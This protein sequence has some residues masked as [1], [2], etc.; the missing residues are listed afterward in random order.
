MPD[1]Y[2]VHMVSPDDDRSTACG[3]PWPEGPGPL[4]PDLV[5]PPEGFRVD[6]P[7][8]YRPEQIRQCAAC[9]RIVLQ[10]G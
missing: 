6:P 8:H 1:D 3:A 4:D 7:A 9:R 5:I 10:R 2:I